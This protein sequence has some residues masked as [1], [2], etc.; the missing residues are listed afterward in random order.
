MAA[1]WF[2]EDFPK[3]ELR[4]S[5]GPH[6]DAVVAALTG[7]AH[8]TFAAR[9]LSELGYQP[10][11][12]T[13][14]VKRGG[15]RRLGPG[16]YLAGLTEP[17][18][19]SWRAAAIH[20]GGDGAVL[21]DLTAIAHLGGRVTEPA[22]VHI[23]VPTGR[24]VARAQL[25]A[26]DA[27]VLP[28]ERTV[29]AGLPC[30]TWPRALLDVAAHR[31][32]DVL[33][34]AWR[35]AVYRRQ[36]HEPAMERVLE[37]H[38]GEPGTVLFR[39]LWEARLVAIGRSANKMES[40]LRDIVVAAGLPEPRRNMRLR[41]DGVVLRPDLYI[42]ERRLALETDG[43]DGHG[44]PEQQLEDARRDALYRRMG[45]DPVRHG[46]WPITYRAADLEDD[47]ARFEAWWQ[48]TAGTPR[49]GDPRPRFRLARR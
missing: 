37:D 28:H 20:A 8:G 13:R 3:D 19:L 12:A 23:I 45:L 4:A 38:R 15:L 41:I 43:K 29:V 47:F 10:L 1:A 46:W 34:H 18:A 42:P 35:E 44:D 33:E 49:P 16:V 2:P 39:E 26:R 36:V 40:D 7:A 14:R 5:S 11:R 30:L 24:R 25:S 9:Q 22:D 32:R 6:F 48:R 27:I 17:T 21:A 31:P